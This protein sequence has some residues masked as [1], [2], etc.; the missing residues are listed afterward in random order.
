MLLCADYVLPI[1]SDP[2]ESGAVLVRNGK[3]K[4]VGPA[5]QL[6]ARYADEEVRDFGQ[7]A[8]MPGFVNVHSHVEYTVMRGVVHDVPYAQWLPLVTEKSGAL[9]AADLY[10]SALI[11]GLE[12]LA[13]GITTL[14]DITG[15]ESTV[16]ALNALGMRGVIY[17]EVGAMDR[18]RVEYAMEAAESDI[19]RW[20]SAV[21]SDLITIGIAPAPL[22]RCHPMIFKLVSEYAGDAIPVAMHLA[23]SQEEYDFIESGSSSLSV[24]IMHRREYMEIP[25]WLPTGVTP[26]NYVLN[27]GAFD[28]KQVMAI[29]CVHVS[30]ADIQK[31]REYDV[32]V[33]FCPRCNAH[34]GMGVAPLDEFRKAGLRIGLGTDSPAATDSGDMFP[35]MR[36]GLMV[37]RAVGGG[38]H[39][40]A[41]HS[42]LEM[43][44]IGGAR[45]LRIDDKVG[46]LE[47]GKRADITAV[48]MSGSHQTPTD[49]PMSALVN[50]GSASDVLMTMVDGNVLYDQNKWHTDVELAKNIAHVMMTRRKL[51][52]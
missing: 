19:E 30:D 47:V 7:A 25:P 6:R 24:E 12:A 22:Y 43:A 45:A 49:T 28:A 4:D 14:G 52:K 18:R 29:H 42:M 50:T 5:D 37:Q 16:R 27:W 38:R 35:E 20:T 32:A 33:G 2:I 8:L 26:A 44:T 39:F 9:T 3:I 1:T 17:R 10:D 13:S 51:R 34:L 15:S 36:I 23:G 21:N 40:L 46:S 31:M 11:G 41:A 48:D